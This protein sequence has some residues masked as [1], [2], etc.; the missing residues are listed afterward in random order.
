MNRIHFIRIDKNPIHLTLTI[1]LVICLLIAVIE[2]FHLENPKL[3]KTFYLIGMFLLMVLNG[4]LFWF[5]NAVQWNK[6]GIVIK[7]N[8]V[9]KH[10][11]IAFEQI[12]GAEIIKNTLIISRQSKK[13]AGFN[14]Q[15]IDS[16]DTEKL[17]D[18]LH[19]HSEIPA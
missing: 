18:I 4:R 13:S 14:L 9:F 2:P 5:K 11:S 16:S 15:N 17:L 3:Y 7:L 1:T 8:T 6:K 10:K 19:R 12:T